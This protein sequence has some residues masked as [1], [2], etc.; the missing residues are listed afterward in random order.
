MALLDEINQRSKEIYT[1]GYPMSIGELSSLYRD[2]ELDIHPE[3]QRIFRW[4]IL[5]KSK[6]I[7]SLLLGIP[8][9]SI[10][11]S[12]REDGVWDVVDGLQRLSTI[13]EFMGI[14]R[15]DDNN[16]L[17][18]SRLVGTDLLP[19][20][21]GKEWENEDPNIDFGN[22][23]RIEIKRVKLDV[24]IVKKQSDK[25]IKF[26]LF[27][28]LNTLGTRLSDQEVRNCLLIMINKD[29]Y[30]WIKNLAEYPSFLFSTSL[31]ERLIDE[32]YHLEIALRFFIYKNIDLDEIKGVYDL[33]DFVTKKMITYADSSDFDKEK[34]ASIFK[35]TFDFVS[36]YL[37]DDGFKKYNIGKDKFQGM[38]LLS[39]FEAI[40]I[41]IGKNIESGTLDA[42]GLSV[43]S[44][45]KS[46][47]ENT[48]FQKRSGS[49]VSVSS[50]LPVLIPLGTSLFAQ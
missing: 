30:Y 25:N 23:L 16:F 2:S 43:L 47:W 7:E 27:Q 38:F 21:E 34:E 18:K 10:F 35:S 19:S 32:Q 44:K 11:V 5:Q 48:D 29:F 24:K 45:A 13:F 28:R 39:A 49:G 31:A 20:L 50:R 4:K 37:E 6:L 1:D 14:L 41:G 22:S 9:P 42:D 33:A 15:D 36:E 26:E 3:F 12:Q 46:M 17:P 40:A 8:V